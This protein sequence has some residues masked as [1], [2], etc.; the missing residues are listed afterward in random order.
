MARLF[1]Q[2][3]KILFLYIGRVKGLAPAI[4]KA[5]IKAAQ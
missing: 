2:K 5:A 4:K 1:S 3:K